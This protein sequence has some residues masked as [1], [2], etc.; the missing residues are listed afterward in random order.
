V[1]DKKDTLAPKL[2]VSKASP[3]YLPGI[4]QAGTDCLHVGKV[5]PPYPPGDQA[6]RDG[7][8]HVSKNAFKITRNIVSQG[9]PA[10]FIAGT[11]IATVSVLTPFALD[12]NLR[13][14]GDKSPKAT[15]KQAAQKQAK[16]NAANQKKNNASSAKQV[17]KPK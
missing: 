17:P 7:L 9:R 16:A 10:P 3:P 8:P 1:L 5:S 12:L 2:P 13:I 14:M 6:S 11:E 4:E 15:H